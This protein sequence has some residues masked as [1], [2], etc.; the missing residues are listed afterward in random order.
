M[1]KILSIWIIAILCLGLFGC[2]AKS[3]PQYNEK[4]NQEISFKGWTFQIPK[5]WKKL[6]DVDASGEMELNDGEGKELNDTIG[7]LEGKEDITKNVLLLDFYGNRS[8][9]SYVQEREEYFGY[10]KDVK[11]IEQSRIAV[12][13]MPAERIECTKTIADVRRKIVTIII[14]SGNNVIEIYFLSNTEHGYSDFEKVL[15]SM[16]FN[17]E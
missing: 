11:D 10:D 13:N 17:G 2:G 8:F 9:E 7:F 14:K 15:D 3:E 6:S 4:T 1:K 12:S 16:K 5:E